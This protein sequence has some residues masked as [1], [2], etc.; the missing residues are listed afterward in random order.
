MAGRAVAGEQLAAVGLGV[1]E[2]HAADRFDVG[3]VGVADQQAERQRE[4]DA[5]HDD[6]HTRVQQGARPA[7][8]AGRGPA[9]ARGEGEGDHRETHEEERGDEQSKG[10]HRRGR[11]HREHA[12]RRSAGPPG[13][14]HQR[15]RPWAKDMTGGRHG[16]ESGAPAG[17]RGGRALLLPAL[18]L[19]LV[20]R[21]EVLDL[22]GGTVGAVERPSRRRTRTLIAPATGGVALQDALGQDQRLGPDRRAGGARRPAGGTTRLIVPCSSS[23]SMKHDALRRPGAL[24]GDDQPADAHAACRGRSC[25]GRRSSPLR[26]ASEPGRSSP[27]G[28]VAG[29]QAGRR[30]VGDHRVPVAAAGRSAGAAGR[31][32]GSA[33][34]VPC[35]PFA[36][37]RRGDA[38]PPERLAARVAPVARRRR[39][40][41]G[42]R[43][44]ELLERGPPGARARGQVA[45]ASGTGRRAR[46][47][48]RA[49]PPPR[50]APRA[51]SPSPSRTGARPPSTSGAGGA[52]VDVRRQHR[53]A[54]ALRLVDERVGR[55]E[56]HRLLVEQRARGTRARSA[57][58]ARSTGRRAG[59]RRRRGPWGSRSRRSPRSSCQTRS[60][61]ASSTSSQRATA[62]STKRWW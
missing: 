61:S 19:P 17:G 38:Q 1:R 43:P 20:E 12:G 53:D 35:R 59:R 18:Q 51:R 16:T 14:A 6:R 33:S 54:A 4:A 60:A 58:A 23:S 13:G 56:A 47:R 7:G 11:L 42:A 46:A 48:R 44:G 22:R 15:L 5:D 57:R 55:V 45:R 29:R 28:C 21:R 37:G 39:A 36:D 50:P 27:S 34:C 2:V 10:D 62:P 41:A 31:S 8:R 32:S 30:V 26:R 9:T 24:A 25:R 40:V 3:A 49:P 52:G